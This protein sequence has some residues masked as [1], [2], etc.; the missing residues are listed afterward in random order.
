ME[1]ERL[2]SIFNELWPHLGE[3]ERRLFAAAEAKAIGHGGVTIISSVCGLSRVTITK[4]IK[5]LTEA[6][7]EN[8]RSRKPGAGRPSVQRRDPELKAS[9]VEILDD[10]T[11][12]DP[13]SPLKWT[14]KRT[15][16]ISAALL[17]R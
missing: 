15:R 9:L 12:G 6:P 14:T 5:E 16:T 3:R 1:L 2:T 4:G 11:R 17:K 13:E 8:R 10:T 7:L